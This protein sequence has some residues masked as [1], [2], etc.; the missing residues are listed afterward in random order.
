MHVSFLSL[1]ID[2]LGHVELERN[3]LVGLSVQRL[4]DISHVRRFEDGRRDDG[5]KIDDDG[6]RAAQTRADFLPALISNLLVPR[7]A[8]GDDGD[9]HDGDG[10]DF[11]AGIRLGVYLRSSRHWRVRRVH[12]R[13]SL[14]EAGRRGRC[15]G[16]RGGVRRRICT[17]G[18]ARRGRGQ[19]W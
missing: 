15:A 5:R 8:A 18:P 7:Q 2:H 14:G 12:G 6:T 4:G 13:R 3:F 10:D 17:C 11:H 1:K 19:V 9:D 16:R